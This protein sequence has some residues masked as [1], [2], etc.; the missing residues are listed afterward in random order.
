[1]KTNKVIHLRILS[2]ATSV[3]GQGVGAAYLE[4]L[5]L[6]KQSK[7]IHI[8]PKGKGTPDLYHVHTINFRYWLAMLTIRKPKVVYVHFLP[9]TLSS[10]IKLPKIFFG[11]LKWYV[12]KFYQTASHLVVV[13]PIFIDPLVKMGIAR[14]KIQFIPNYV[15]EKK[16]IT[17][18]SNQS[19]RKTFQFKNFTVL[20]V[21]QV[22]HRKGVLD[23]IEIAK[24]LPHIDFV[25]AGGFSFKSMTAGYQELKKVMDNP[26]GNVRFLG[27]IPRE[28][29]NEL[30]HATDLFFLPSFDELMPMSVLEAAVCDKPILLRDLELYKPVFFKHYL[31][32]HNVDGFVKII[33]QLSTNKEMYQ[34]ALDHPRWLKNYY[35]QE[36]ILKQWEDYYQEVMNQ[37]GKTH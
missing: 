36:A 21:G 20:G 6:I 16:F 32:A 12:K 22:Q 35:R 27:I 3:P 13:N 37:Y 15:D 5:N 1:V 33:E 17:N 18:Q 4:Q 29:M 34:Q 10:S 28:K 2:Q 31:S 25:W 26:P 14:E 8:L 9:S 11:I 19:L 23:F 30:Y 24:R 7:H